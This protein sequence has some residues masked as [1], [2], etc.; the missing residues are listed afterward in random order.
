LGINVGFLV[1]QIVNLVIL[2]L[3]LRAVLYKPVLNMLDQRAQHI[4]QGLHDAE[5]AT[6]KASQAEAEYQR[7]ME[8]AK[9]QAQGIIE[10]AAAQARKVQEETLTKAQGEAQELLT[11]AH[12]QIDAERQEAL[13]AM[14]QQVAELALAISSKLISQSLDDQTHRRLID[15]FLA[16]LT[17][18]T[19]PSTGPRTQA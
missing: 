8:E 11:R 13:R 1:S 3:L 9:R 18:A 2:L 6:Q 12:Q 17:Q 19:P 14:R 4:K 16:E 5:L 7:R 10:Q 15:E